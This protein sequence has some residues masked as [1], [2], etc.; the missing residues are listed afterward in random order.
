MGDAFLCGDAF[1][2]GD[3]FLLIGDA[4][5]AEDEEDDEHEEDEEEV[6]EE[7]DDEELPD[8]EDEDEVVEPPD[9][10]EV[11]SSSDDD[12]DELDE[13]EDDEEDEELELLSLCFREAFFLL[14]GDLERFLLSLVLLRSLLSSSGSFLTFTLTS[15]DVDSTRS[16]WSGSGASCL[17]VPSPDAFDLFMLFKELPST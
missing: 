13:A 8:D 6:D 10:D 2:V 7:L 15:A 12:E 11:E 14:L 4:D 17:F 9:D 1:L 3:A 16:L 5:G